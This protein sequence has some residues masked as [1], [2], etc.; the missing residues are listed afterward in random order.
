ME[1]KRGAFDLRNQKKTN[2]VS[3]RIEKSN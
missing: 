3:L 1:T 2:P